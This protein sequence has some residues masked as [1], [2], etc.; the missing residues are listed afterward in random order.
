M[1]LC[2]NK[3]NINLLTFSNKN[4][5]LSAKRLVRQ[6]KRFGVFKKFILAT[7]QILIL[8]LNVNIN[9]LN[10]KKRSRILDLKP[11]V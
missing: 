10:S 6:A 4:F 7:N 11:Y 8:T 5:S 9:I 3:K 1:V 2:K